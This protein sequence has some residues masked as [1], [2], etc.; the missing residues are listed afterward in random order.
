MP[1]AAVLPQTVRPDNASEYA[2]IGLVGKAQNLRFLASVEGTATV[3]KGRDTMSTS[4]DKQLV[5][6]DGELPDYFTAHGPLYKNADLT[7]LSVITAE[8]SLDVD[9]EEKKFITEVDAI[10]YEEQLNTVLEAIRNSVETGLTTSVDVGIY[11]G[12]P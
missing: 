6:R 2:G 3:T 1:W 9:P 12:N 4:V 8:I 10:K 7:D 11:L 5:S